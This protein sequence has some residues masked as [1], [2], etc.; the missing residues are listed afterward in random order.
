M[1]MTFKFGE[2]D[3]ALADLNRIPSS[4]RSAFAARLKNLHRL[5]YPRGVGEGR[6]RAVNYTVADLA[7]MAIAI[8]LCQLGLLPER[9]VH[10]LENDPYQLLMAIMMGARAAMEADHDEYRLADDQSQTPLSMFLYFDPSV[11]SGWHAEDGDEDGE[12]FASSTFFYGG[13]GVVREYMNTWTT[14]LTTR[15]SLINVTYLL[16]QL[17]GLVPDRTAFLA[18]VAEWADLESTKG[19]MDLDF[20]L[21]GLARTRIAEG[22]LG[23]DAV[24]GAPTSL[25][26]TIKRSGFGRWYKRNWLVKCDTSAGEPDLFI[27][28]PGQRQLGVDA[29]FGGRDRQSPEAIAERIAFLRTRPFRNQFS[30]NTKYTVMFLQH[31]DLMEALEHDPALW[32]NA[33]DEGVI[34]VTP[35]AFTYLL[36]GVASLWVETH[37]AATFGKRGTGNGHG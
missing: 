21:A 33:Y 22:L 19:D 18:E 15:I 7:R 37:D 31:R 1:G 8:E 27:N 16:W 25:A 11:L 17:S 5:D 24:G 35:Q 12:D 30:D 26:A 3:A 4:A 36:H 20:W 9:A 14:G 28:L 6:G 34:M 32:D 13:E 23:I 2:I 29:A 10:V